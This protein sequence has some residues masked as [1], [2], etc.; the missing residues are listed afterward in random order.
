VGH[1]QG[2]E[3]KHAY[4]SR[5]SFTNVR[6]SL[7]ACVAGAAVGLETRNR[8]VRHEVRSC[9]KTEMSLFLLGWESDGLSFLEISFEPPHW[10]D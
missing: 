9:A 7:I 4:Y 10:R 5:K 8:C 1:I 2:A 6:G 3:E